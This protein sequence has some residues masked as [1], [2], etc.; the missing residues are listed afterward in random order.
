MRASGGMR[1]QDIVVL[2]KLLVSQNKPIKVLELAYELGLSQS[3]VSMALERCRRAGLVDSSKKRPL[4][5]A[6]KEFLLYGVKYVFPG[7]LGSVVRGLPTAH[8]APPL[9][10]KIV[11]NDKESERYVWPYAE[12]KVRG[13]AIEPL[14]PS[15]PAAADRDAKL[16]EVLALIDAI[17]VGRAREKKIAAEELEKHFA[18]L[19]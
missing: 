3:E 13:I 1:P 7:E 9:S 16:Y 14:Y 2:A 17:R 6:L 8:S 12:G 10:K 18:E 15:V 11:S 5:G 19:G 4:P